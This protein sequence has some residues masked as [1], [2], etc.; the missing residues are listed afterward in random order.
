MSDQT[1]AAYLN[2]NRQRHLDEVGAWLRIP[3]VRMC[4]L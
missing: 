4:A 2:D 3:S 1:I